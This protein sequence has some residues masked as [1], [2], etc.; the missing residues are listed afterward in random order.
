MGG[1]V[2]RHALIHTGLLSVAGTLFA[3]LQ[4]QAGLP[5]ASPHLHFFCWCFMK[6]LPRWIFGLRLLP[7]WR[8][9]VTAPSAL[10]PRCSSPAPRGSA[11]KETSF[12]HTRLMAVQ[13]SSCMTHPKSALLL[14]VQLNSDMSILIGRVIFKCRAHIYMCSNTSSFSAD[15]IYQSRIVPLYNNL[16]HVNSFI[17]V[18]QQV[19]VRPPVC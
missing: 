19:Q 12:L 7:G 17:W 16:K 1:A 8:A 18:R 2:P 9:V 3:S 4:Y 6:V 5:S 10:S 11:P 13:K 15:L 14:S